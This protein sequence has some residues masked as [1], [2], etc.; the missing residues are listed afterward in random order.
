MK[1]ISGASRQNIFADWIFVSEKGLQVRIC[2]FHRRGKQLYQFSLS[3]FYKGNPLEKNGLNREKTH[4]FVFFIFTVP[5]EV[6]N[7]FFIFPGCKIIFLNT[8][9]KKL[10]EIV[11]YMTSKNFPEKMVLTVRKP[12]TYSKIPQ[13]TCVFSRAAKPCP[14]NAICVFLVR[15]FFLNRFTVAFPQKKC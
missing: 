6:K 4:F 12:L 14:N 5:H 7:V 11:F 8:W 10:F 1:K 9:R 15:F 13:R 3:E 2:V